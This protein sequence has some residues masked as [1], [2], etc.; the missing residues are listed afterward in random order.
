MRTIHIIA[1]PIFIHGDTSNSL[2][3][4]ERRLNWKRGGAREV[5]AVIVTEDSRTQLPEIRKWKNT[6]GIG[7]WVEHNVQFMS[8]LDEHGYSIP[9]NN[10][11]DEALYNKLLCEFVRP[12]DQMFAGS[13]LEVKAFRDR[14]NE[15]ILTDLFI[16]SG[17]Y[18]LI[19]ADTQIVPYSFSINSQE[20]LRFLD[21][22]TSVSEGILETF[23]KYDIGI[24]VLPS[25][26]LEYFSS[27]GL[28]QQLAPELPIIVVGSTSIKQR[29]P[30]SNIILHFPRKGVARIGK[31]NQKSIISLVKRMKRAYQ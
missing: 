10:I 16:I 27:I 15:G 1:H 6:S 28:F 14:L 19:S 21:M 7:G 18:G 2:H 17:R 13:F 12:A 20:D 22:M 3:E 23:K 11:D 31:T 24:I 4:K 26:Y 25:L 9:T 30:D 29:V 5:K 8:C